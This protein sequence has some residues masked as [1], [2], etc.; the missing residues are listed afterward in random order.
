MATHLQHHS[1]H[2]TTCQTAHSNY[3]LLPT[4]CQSYRVRRRN[5]MSDKEAQSEAHSNRET[6]IYLHFC[7]LL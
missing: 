7:W 1:A 4:S 2:L 6:A 3:T 5:A